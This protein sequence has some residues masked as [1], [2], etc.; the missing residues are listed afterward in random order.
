M[1]VLSLF[2][3]RT[4]RLWHGVRPIITS[5]RPQQIM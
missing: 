3:N 4:L 1:D 2:N 5:G